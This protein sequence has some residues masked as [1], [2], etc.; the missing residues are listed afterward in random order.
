MSSPVR[1]VDFQ[2]TLRRS[3]PCRYSRV[4]MS[5]LP[6]AATLRAVDSPPP[7]QSPP[8]R[9]GGSGLTTGVTTSSSV[10]AK[11]RASST[12]PNGS[13]SRTDSGPTV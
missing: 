12:R 6:L 8:R 5:S 4:L 7:A 10:V 3:S 2:W 9:T 11:A 1:A 13:V